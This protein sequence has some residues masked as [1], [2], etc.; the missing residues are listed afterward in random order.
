MEEVKL[1]N[2]CTHKKPLIYVQAHIVFGL[3]LPFFKC[4]YDNN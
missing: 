1:H 4:I 3:I 2:N